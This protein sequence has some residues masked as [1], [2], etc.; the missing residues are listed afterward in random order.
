VES[1][2]Y[3]KFPFCCSGRADNNSMEREINFSMRGSMK[4]IVKT[5]KES[6]QT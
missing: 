6:H 5:T 3:E 4:P 1:V 2:P